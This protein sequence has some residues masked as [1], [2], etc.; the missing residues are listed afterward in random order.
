MACGVLYG[1]WFGLLAAIAGYNLGAS[2]GF[3]V[4]RYLLREQIV[5]WAQRHTVARLSLRVM[6]RR[7]AM[8]VVVCRVAPFLPWGPS[9]YL[10]SLSDVSY[11][12]YC[13][14][15]LPSSVPYCLVCVLAGV[16]LGDVAGLHED[17]LSPTRLGFPFWGL[18]AL[19]NVLMLGSGIWGWRYGRQLLREEERLEQ[20][21][22]RALGAELPEAAPPGAAPRPGAEPD[23]DLRAGRLSAELSLGP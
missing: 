19:G 3:L 5:A 4:G 13:I 21:E 16:G 18:V 17:D 22:Q 14:A 15:T 20:I 2:C 12:H 11:G 9:N 6:D 10:F 8:F 7:P 23:A 1:H